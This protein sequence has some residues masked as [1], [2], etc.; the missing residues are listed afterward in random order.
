[1]GFLSKLWSDVVNVIKAVWHD[2]M[3][4][5]PYVLLIL[6]LCFGLGWFALPEL[7]AGV[8]FAITAWQGVALCLGLA[9]LINPTEST[10]IIAKVGQIAGTIVSAIVTA[11]AGIAG[12]AASSFLSSPFG[13]VLLGVGAFMLFG[14][15]DDGNR[16][17]AQSG[18]RK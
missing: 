12:S 2:I 1:M 6:A 17:T 10:A 18:T 16:S 4:I 8:G 5:L 3:V 9:F 13:L 11:A 15:H 7:L 14:R